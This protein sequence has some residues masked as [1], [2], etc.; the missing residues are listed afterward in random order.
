MR[1]KRAVEPARR[2]I[3][4]VL[5]AGGMA[6]PGDPG[7]G[8]E[9]LLSAQRQFVFEQQ[10]EP[11][12][13]IETAGFGLVFEFLEPLGQA[14]ETE[15]VE[16]VE[17]GMGEH[18]LFLSMVVAGAAQVGVLEQRGGRLFPG[19][20]F[21]DLAVEQRGDAFV[22]EDAEFERSGGD[23]FEPGRIEAAIGARNSETGAKPLFGMR[24]AGE[25]GGDQALGVGSDLAGPATE[26]IRRPLGVT[27]VGARHVLWVR[28][29]LAA[30][31]AALVTATRW[32][33]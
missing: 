8:F 33:R 25:Y 30:P 18:G 2:L 22:I 9:L 29:V 14:V 1:N 19:G 5:D 23:R 28:A 26:P 6:Q 31:V 4:D 13:V 11:F 32:P 12:G 21:V 27:A 20:G 10:P 3:I 17:R 24:P 7:A 15:R 16:L